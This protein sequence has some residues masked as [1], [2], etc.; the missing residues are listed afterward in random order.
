MQ[1]MKA[2]DMVAPAVT[3]FA[4][5]KIAA[6]DRADPSIILVPIQQLLAESEKRRM[7]DAVVFEYDRPVYL[8]ENPVKAGRDPSP[9]A[10]VD[11][12]KVGADIAG[13]VDP[14][15]QHTHVGTSFH[16]IR[17]IGTWT[18][19]DH[20]ELPRPRRR[21]RGQNRP[22]MLRS[23]EDDEGDGWLEVRIAH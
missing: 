1:G 16:V 2:R 13:P 9:D 19:S 10:K 21:D 4:H 18:V 6:S 5:Q 20:E 23:V 15:D 22:R 11:I 8:F 12:R 3:G 7:R 17:P 14:L